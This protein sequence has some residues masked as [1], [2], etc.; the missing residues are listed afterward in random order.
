MRVP[1]RCLT[2]LTSADECTST[3]LKM[4]IRSMP[5]SSAMPDFREKQRWSP[6]RSFGLEH[7][8]A[9]KSQSDFFGGSDSVAASSS[10][11]IADLKTYLAGPTP[12]S[13]GGQR[14][15][16]E[17]RQLEDGRTFSDLRSSLHMIILEQPLTSLQYDIQDGACIWMV[18]R[19]RG[20]C[21][22]DTE[23]R[24]ERKAFGVRR[25]DRNER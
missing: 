18:N 12:S 19:L 9:R 2:S 25:A 10:H 8:R 14:L 17:G 11:T 7:R 16:C 4:T 1:S 24:I 5:R 23:E 20:S 15:I 22:E 6:S 21:R 3:V 13:P